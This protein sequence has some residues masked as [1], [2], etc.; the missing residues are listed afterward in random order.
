MVDDPAVKTEL[1]KA[2]KKALLSEVASEELQAFTDQVEAF[3]QQMRQQLESVNEKFSRGPFPEHE[4]ESELAK[5]FG[6]DLDSLEDWV[7]EDQEGT[8]YGWPEQIAIPTLS[9]AEGETYLIY[10]KKV[11]DKAELALALRI[12]AFYQQYSGCESAP[13]VVAVSHYIAPNTRTFA[14]QH[15]IELI[16][17]APSA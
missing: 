6:A 9:T 15:N 16:C 14:E 4:A 3:K 1:L 17:I 12:L 2:M 11:F 13:R 7:L 5:K 8:V 10:Q